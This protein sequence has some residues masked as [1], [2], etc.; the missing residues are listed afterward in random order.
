MF[1][2]CKHLFRLLRYDAHLHGL[3][4]I[5]AGQNTG[6]IVISAVCI[7]LLLPVYKH[8]TTFTDHVSFLSHRCWNYQCWNRRRAWRNTQR[9]HVFILC[10]SLRCL[11]WVSWLLNISPTLLHNSPSCRFGH[12]ALACVLS[13]PVSTFRSS[14]PRLCPQGT[15][16]TLA[17]FPSHFS[18]IAF[19]FQRPHGSWRMEKWGE[20]HCMNKW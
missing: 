7:L 8:M 14:T 16:P 4:I 11:T 3:P 1:R 9:M 6:L 17:H 10:L 19:I 5:A 13:L 2:N 15:C 20:N 12:W 18:L